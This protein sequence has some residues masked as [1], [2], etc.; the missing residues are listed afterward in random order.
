MFKRL[1]IANRGEIACRIIHS[2][3]RMGIQTIAVYSEV[4][5]NALH[6]READE[7]HLL[8]PAPSSESYLNIPKILELAKRTKAEAIHPG[9]GFVSQNPAFANAC[10][11]AGIIFV[12]PRAEAM[13]AMGDKVLA[14]N[15]GLEAGLPLVPG[16]DKEVSD[17]QAPELAS[18]LGYPIMVK[19]AEGGGGI[20]VRAVRR[21]KSLESILTRSRTL[22][23]GAFG[24]SRVYLERLVENASHVEVQVLADEHGNAVHLFERDCS[25]QRR[26]QKIVEET[27]CAKIDPELQQ[28]LCNAAL[29]LVKHIGYTN[30]GT[31]EFLVDPARRFY[32]L[33][34]NTRLQV[35]HG[36][37][38]LCTGLD[39]V[40]LQLRIA[41]GEKLPFKQ[42]DIK[43]NGHAIEARIYPEDPA[44]MMPTVGKVTHLE[45]P[46]GEGVR[47]DSALFEGYAVTPYYESMMAKLMTWAPTRDQAIAR[48]QTALKQF[49]IDGLT[50]N[51]PLI[52]DVLADPMFIKH[53]YDTTMLSKMSSASHPGQGP[54]AAAGDEVDEDVEGDLRETAAAV[55]LALALTDTKPPQQ[56]KRPAVS[57]ASRWVAAGR[58]AQVL[59]RINGR[60]IW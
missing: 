45:V 54:S 13:Q 23:K 29:A 24:S 8:G 43:Q 12:G 59:A 60:S 46:S 38:E 36:I 15:L 53:T 21:P 37:T 19:A 30:A 44:T 28:A 51:I 31:V 32:F 25:V 40:E 41:A 48:M 3:K 56:R 49:R 47:L 55:G 17:E 58:A 20:G 5:A 11:D 57:T 26:H 7:A 33:E 42:S 10:R 6:V 35:E 2:A 16:L 39:L 27:P 52:Q 1:L 50:I 22:A 18:I 4:D 14:R 9:Y 34:M